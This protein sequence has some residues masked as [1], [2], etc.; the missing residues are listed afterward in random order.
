MITRRVVG[1]RIDSEG[2]PCS[3]RAVVKADELRQYVDN[4]RTL[5]RQD[6]LRFAS[7][8]ERQVQFALLP[9]LSGKRA[10][11][12]P[13]LW[14]LLFVCIAGP[15]ACAPLL[16]EE[17]WQRAVDA[18]ERGTFWESDEAAPFPK[19]ARAVWAALTTLR[20]VGV[21]PKPKL[22]V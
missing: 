8:V 17:T 15:T 21:Y 13:S 22:M 3:T 20:E 6:G 11:L 16:S 14:D 2:A 4:L 12:E 5:L 9:H 7:M 10:D 18:V 1:G 19:A